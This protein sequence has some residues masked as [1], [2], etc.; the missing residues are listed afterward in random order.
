MFDT[1]G[2]EHRPRVD[3]RSVLNLLE[4][5]LTKLNS[6][7]RVLTHLL[8][9]VLVS[10]DEPAFHRFVDL[11]LI[12]TSFFNFTYWHEVPHSGGVMIVPWLCEAPFFFSCILAS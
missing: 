12:D 4:S 8:S 5:A 2:V 9:L 1:S 11:V 10:I 6:L 3:A 7:K